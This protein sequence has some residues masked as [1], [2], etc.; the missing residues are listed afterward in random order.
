MDQGRLEAVVRRLSGPAVILGSSQPDG[1]VDA[2]AARAAGLEVARRRSGG[3]AVLVVPGETVWLDVTVPAAH[4]LWDADVRRSF[5]WLGRAWTAAL[6]RHGIVADWHRDG[7][8]SSRWSRLVCFAALGPGEVHRHG[9]KVVGM[10]Q[11][12]SRPGCLFQCLV[13]LRFDAGALVGVL[14]LPDAERA[15]AVADVAP[16]VADLDTAPGFEEALVDSFLAEISAPRLSG[17]GAGRDPGSG[18]GRR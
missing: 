11:R 4:P 14:A 17:A 16:R 7:L 5:H 3:G 13:N 10:S 12:R 18:P 1:T 15:A 2:P 8:C 6:A 9:R